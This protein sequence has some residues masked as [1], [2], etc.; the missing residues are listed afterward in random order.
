M[1]PGVSKFLEIVVGQYLKLHYQDTVLKT[2]NS[3]PFEY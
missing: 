3:T 2:E 1:N